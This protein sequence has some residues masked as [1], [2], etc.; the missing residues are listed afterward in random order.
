M[1]VRSL[2]DN[3]E[4]EPK[5]EFGPL[6]QDALFEYNDELEP[7]VVKCRADLERAITLV[8]D[9]LRQHTLPLLDSLS[10]PESIVRHLEENPR[11]S[12]APRDKTEECLAFYRAISLKEEQALADEHKETS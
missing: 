12:V 9:L 10:D 3:V 8:Q 7:I 1:L 11:A 2:I 5:P 6:F 4:V